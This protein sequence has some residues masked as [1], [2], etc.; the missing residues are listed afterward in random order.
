MPRATD[1]ADRKVGA[2]HPRLPFRTRAAWRRWLEA[3]HTRRA[4]VW[5]LFR[6]KSSSVPSVRYN[7]AVEE[8]LC[9]GW[10]DSIVKSVDAD[11]YVQLFTPRKP[12]SVWSK[13]NKIRVER[14][15]EAGLMTPAG[16]EK[17]ETARR[18][19]AW[20]SYDSVEALEIPAD[21]RSALARHQSAR[22]NFER[23]SPSRKKALLY[24][25]ITAKRPETRK[26]RIER[27]VRLASENRVG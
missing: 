2:A 22:D 3:N 20:E 21:F 14:L 8:A 26:R 12:K 4:G 27:A 23:F 16:L 19:G 11:S 25:I 6:K 13:S 18:N 9:F 17:V 7:D 10:I 1:M 24:L 15:I 5:L